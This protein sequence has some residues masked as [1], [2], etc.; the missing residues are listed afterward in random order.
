MHSDTA[1]FYLFVF[2]IRPP[3]ASAGRCTGLAHYV[4]SQQPC[5]ALGWILQ[6][7]K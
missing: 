5:N 1:I 4:C 7:L 3:L 6:G 2:L